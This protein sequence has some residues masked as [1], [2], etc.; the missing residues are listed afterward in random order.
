METRS[1]PDRQAGK[2]RR[3]SVYRHTGALA[4][5]DPPEVGGAR[6]LLQE[7]EQELRSSAARK[8]ERERAGSREVREESREKGCIFRDV[9]PP[10]GMK[11]GWRAKGV[12]GG[13]EVAR[14]YVKFVKG[15]KK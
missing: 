4:L 8:R 2:R 10:G 15:Q 13:L 12:R 9:Y 7:G 1:R 3:E 6:S 11:L 14:A 5:E